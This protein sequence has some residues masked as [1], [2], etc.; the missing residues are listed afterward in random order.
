MLTYAKTR[1]FMFQLS[2]RCN[3]PR[4]IDFIISI[5]WDHN[6]VFGAPSIINSGAASLC[7][8]DIVVCVGKELRGRNVRLKNDKNDNK[9]AYKSRNDDGTY[10]IT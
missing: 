5:A 6:D 9:F 3:C 7:S 1:L 10:F 8:K 2:I 4:I